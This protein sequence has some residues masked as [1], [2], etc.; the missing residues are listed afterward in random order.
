MDA[1]ESAH[2]QISQWKNDGIMP[3]EATLV[4]EDDRQFGIAKLYSQY[5]R[6]LHAYNAFDLDDLILQTA[7]L[8]KT[9][10]D[11]LE[12]WQ[13]NIHYLLVDEYQDTNAM[14]YELVRM[15]AEK[16]QCLT[17]VGDDDQSI[18]A[19]RG[20]KPENLVQLSKDF[21]TLQVI[22]LEQNYRSSRRI[23]KLAN[24]LIK[25]NPHVYEKRLWSDLGMGRALALSSA[26]A[27]RMKVSVSAWSCSRTRSRT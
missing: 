20:A 24:E 26:I 23:L 14:Q 2:W 13:H 12:K 8:F 9:R 4:A 18:Y 6:Q 16:R 11:I 25:N 5:Q 19:W 3:E 27:K 10:K 21:P 15:L 22:K 17:A 1:A 7:H